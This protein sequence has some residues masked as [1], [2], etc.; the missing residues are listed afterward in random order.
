M[1]SAP[2]YRQGR[3]YYK[4]NKDRQ[5]LSAIISVILIFL[6]VLVPPIIY[7]RVEVSHKNMCNALYEVLF[8]KESI[9]SLNKASATENS[10]IHEH[11]EISHQTSVSDQEM[12]VSVPHAL[13]LRR[14]T[15]YCQWEE[16]QTEVCHKTCTRTVEA[17]D[18]SSREESY[19]CQCEVRYSYVKS[20]KPYR[21][22]SALFDQFAAHDNPQRDPLPTSTF[23]SGEVF[24][25]LLQD[26][27]KKQETKIKLH[28]DTKLLQN[29]RIPWRKIQ[30]IPQK[31][32]KLSN[33]KPSFFSLAYWGF[34]AGTTTRY[35]DVTL[36]RNTE[37]S[38]GATM[39]N[40]VYVNQGSGYFFSPYQASNLKLMW[41]YFMQY[42]E[43]TLFDWQ[44]GDMMPSCTAGDLRI[45]YK[46][47][48]PPD[49]SVLAQV[50]DS[51]E[52]TFALVPIP[53]NAG[54]SIGF[55]H[56]G[57][58]SVEEMI[59][60]EESESRKKALMARV[61]LFAW[62]FFV[63]H[64]FFT[65]FCG[66]DI[67]NATIWIKIVSAASIWFIVS[68]M[69]WIGLYS[70]DDGITVDM[71]FMLLFGLFLGAIVFRFSPYTKE[72]PGLRAVWCMI[73]RWANLPPGWRVEESYTYQEVKTN[74]SQ[75]DWKNKKSYKY[76]EVQTNIN[77]KA[78]GEQ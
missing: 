44:L 50:S 65:A 47:Q 33:K 45:Y 38:L 9:T 30:W 1:K 27:G 20:W 31:D 48:D 54:P 59:H 6:L 10:V 77:K 74:E 70:R 75:V 58:R 7:N 35:D 23:F 55:V 52:N 57:N 66:A 39:H 8:H 14:N 2:T 64:L 26:G 18:G 43:G 61:L 71:V 37:T 49:I 40:F 4:E 41:K 12:G 5:G 13:S 63:S 62:C 21:V 46:V 36:L 17:K 15:E 34:G 53:T 67:S 3:T 76:E 56:E 72:Q 60:V 24:A 51:G 42:M 11:L 19:P 28:L 68:G 25:D 16:I 69:T 29:A 32:Q 73:G 78:A 22:N